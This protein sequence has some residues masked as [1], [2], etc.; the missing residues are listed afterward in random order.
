MTKSRSWVCTGMMLIV[1]HIVRVAEEL[2]LS[3]SNCC[4]LMA[5][6]DFDG[7]R[8]LLIG[9]RRKNWDVWHRLD[10]LVLSEVMWWR[11]LQ[12]GTCKN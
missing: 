1:V 4:R 8:R 9:E 3:V 7:S 5:Q 12:P 6:W 11:L 10:R 2:W